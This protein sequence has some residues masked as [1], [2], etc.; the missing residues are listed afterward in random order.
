M[1]KQARRDRTRRRESYGE[2]SGVLFMTVFPIVLSSVAYNIS[3][4]IDNSI[5][6]NGM[7]AMGM[8]ASEIASNWGVIG[9]YQL[10]FNIPVA[11]ANSLASALI[12]SLSRAMAEGQRGQL[13]SKVSMVIRFSMLIAIPAQ[14]ALPYW[15]GPSAICYLAGMTIRPLLR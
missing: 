13:K 4:V 12:P 9:K 2:L 8:G 11:I 5:Y 3:T 10:L 6:G 15:Q 1:R 14:W 7:A